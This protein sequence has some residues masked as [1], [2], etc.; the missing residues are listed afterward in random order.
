MTTSTLQTQPLTW[1]CCEVE[2]LARWRES[3]IGLLERDFIIK[4]CQG[5]LVPLGADEGRQSEEYF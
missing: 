3:G 4:N 5:H 2:G 1:T